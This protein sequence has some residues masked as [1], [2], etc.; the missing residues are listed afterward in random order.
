MYL[1]AQGKTT[2]LKSKMISLAK[3]GKPVTFV[4]LRGCTETEHVM[5]LATKIQMEEHSNITVLSSQDLVK[6]FRKQNPWYRSLPSELGLLRFYI[7]RVWFQNAYRKFFFENFR[8]QHLKL[9]FSL[10]SLILNFQ[11][12]ML[13]DFEI[14]QKMKPS[15]I[16]VDE[17]PLE[18]SWLPQMM[19][20]PV[21][22]LIA[23]NKPLTDSLVK[24][25]FFYLF[26]SISCLFFSKIIDNYYPLL[27][28]LFIISG[29][30]LWLGMSAIIFYSQCLHK[31]SKTTNVLKSVVDQLNN[32]SS[33]FLWI[34]LQSNLFNENGC[35]IQVQK[36]DM[37]DWRKIL[38]ASHR[39]CCPMLRHNLRN[40]KAATDLHFNT[41]IGTSTT[42]PR[43]VDIASIPK[44][45]PSLSPTATENSL[46]IPLSSSSKLKDA[47]AHAY[48]HQVFGKPKAV[49]VILE[50]EN[51]LD[52]VV[53]GLSQ[54][55]LDV[56]TYYTPGDRDKCEAFLR[57]P[58]GALVSNGLLLSGMEAACVIWVRG[59]NPTNSN[60][61]TRRAIDK[62]C[63]IC[64]DLRQMGQ[65]WSYGGTMIMDPTFL[66][67]SAPW[68]S[69]FSRCRDKKCKCKTPKRI[70]CNSCVQACSNHS[71]GWD[72][73]QSVFHWVLFFRNP[74]SCNALG[75]CKLVDK[76]S[77]KEKNI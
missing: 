38:T 56:I 67:C 18:T 69:W 61:N 20:L 49:I 29:S 22:T 24:L 53:A 66:S 27:F 73:A 34:A 32:S 33:S 21:Y 26:S 39:F 2:L 41:F 71:V 44:A 9:Y 25:L 1:I 43:S 70:M 75:E 51:L 57:N 40:S 30:L 3:A 13:T 58:K 10:S 8:I 77:L 76:T 16:F 15:N 46:Y 59:P 36:K 5:S 4:F 64:T 14:L 55:G 37:E 19:L 31:L 47:V 54:T 7:Q 11:F 52:D 12:L 45:P 42:V 28:W 23:M 65:A 72:W 62:M 17:A 68:P 50:D 63:I 6:Y 60:S 74:C 48:N 35:G